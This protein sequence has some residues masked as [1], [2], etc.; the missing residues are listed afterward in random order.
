MNL[1]HFE[2]PLNFADNYTSVSCP[3]IKI[4]NKLINTP[5]PQAQNLNGEHT[6]NLCVPNLSDRMIIPGYG[7]N[8]CKN[9]K[10]IHLNFDEKSDCYSKPGCNQKDKMRRCIDP[11]MQN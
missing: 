3:Y 4:K 11:Y 10:P 2:N 6:Q 5:I 1:Q 7:L 8:Y 9:N